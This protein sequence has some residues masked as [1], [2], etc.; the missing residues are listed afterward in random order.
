MYVHL[1]KVEVKPGDSV[2]RGQLIGWSGNTGAVNKNYP[3]MHF[4]I[5]GLDRDVINGHDLWYRTEAEKNEAPWHITVPM[6]DPSITYP[7]GVLT[8]P[9]DCIALA[10][11]SAGLYKKMK[12][13]ADSRIVRK[14]KRPKKITNEE[15]KRKMECFWDST[16]CD[17]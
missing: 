1:S 2:K 7:R 11:I 8:F 17:N 10:E 3:H 12:D 14:S 4:G 6:Y 15:R 5:R 13:D 16:K 9:V